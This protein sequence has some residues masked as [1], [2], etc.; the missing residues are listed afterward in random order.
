MSVFPSSLFSTFPSSHFF[1]QPYPGFVFI[2]CVSPRV[3]PSVRCCPG[4][5]PT[6]WKNG[7]NSSC[8]AKRFARESSSWSTTPIGN[9]WGSWITSLKRG[10]ESP[11][12]QRC[13]GVE[14]DSKKEGEGVVIFVYRGEDVRIYFLWIMIVSF[15]C[16]IL[17]LFI[18]SSIK[19]YCRYFVIR[20]W[21]WYREARWLLLT[22]CHLN[23]DLQERVWRKNTF[24]LGRVS[25]WRF[26]NCDPT[27]LRGDW[28]GL[29]QFRTLLE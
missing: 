21:W 12:F 11:S 23:Y 18:Y 19:T 13:T 8:R 9:L 29:E 2:R 28:V 20:Y 22:K 14:W 16:E 24:E 17:L 15:L 25:E 6:C 1:P 27:V 7:R 26:W 10:I 3:R 5:L 4:F